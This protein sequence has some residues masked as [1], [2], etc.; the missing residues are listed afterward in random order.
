MEQGGRVVLSG[1]ARLL[2]ESYGAAP[3]LQCPAGAGGG[4]SGDIVERQCSAV[5]L[6]GMG[7]SMVV[8][9]SFAE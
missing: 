7:G 3:Q 9:P 1:P 8:R 4:H 6:Y 5:F 2:T